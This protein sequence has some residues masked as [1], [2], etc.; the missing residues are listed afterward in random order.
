MDTEAKRSMSF[1]ADLIG[2]ILSSERLADRGTRLTCVLPAAGQNH[3][4]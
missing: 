4:V 2:A 1:R 3:A